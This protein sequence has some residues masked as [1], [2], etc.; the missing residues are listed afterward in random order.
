MIHDPPASAFQ[1]LGLQA[2]I[3]PPG[4]LPL[5]KRRHI[6]G[7]RGMLVAFLFTVTEKQL[8]GATVYFGWKTM[9]V[10]A[11][12]LGWVWAKLGLQGGWWLAFSLLCL[13]CI[14]NR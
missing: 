11:I 8:E 3:T 14:D 13:A 5:S 10:A 4:C 12:S 2:Y 6:L 7:K 1:G 9:V